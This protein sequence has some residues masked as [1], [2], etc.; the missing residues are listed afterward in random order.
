MVHFFTSNY[1]RGNSP[2][3]IQAVED[4]LTTKQLQDL[5]QVDRVTIYRMLK[6][7]RLAGFK[8]GG[9]WR[10]S[11]QT[12]LQWL[13]EKQ[14][15][16]EQVASSEMPG[17]A[18][19]PQLLSSSCMQAILDI[20]AEALGV[21]SVIT[22]LQGTPLTAVSHP[23]SVCQMILST[24]AGRQRCIDSWSEPRL[25]A[26][27]PSAPSATCHAGLSYLSAPIQVQD[28]VVARIHAGQFLAGIS[29]S[30][31]GQQGSLAEL[32]GAT[33]LES[34]NLAQALGAV[35]RLD[36]ERLHRISD[37]LQRVARTLAEMA[38]ERQSLVG[39][40]QRIAEISQI[41]H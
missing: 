35:P 22:G 41:R 17:L 19:A 11:R 12:I 33:G 1:R 20:F 21:G 4:L 14:V 7:G 6:E 39:R 31:A 26:R 37:L 32:A 13:H 36:R 40:L 29:Q 9:Q 10:F 30:R 5:L 18:T 34:E 3:D 38:E 8:V 27:D 16:Q 28:K 24:E 2:G 25:T 23:C 15:A